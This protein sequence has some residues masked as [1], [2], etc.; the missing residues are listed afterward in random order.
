MYIIYI[1]IR[2]DAWMS[3]GNAFIY[4][5]RNV[6]IM[7]LYIYLFIHA[8]HI[9]IHTTRMHYECEVILEK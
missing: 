8:L 4:V 2:Y 5:M 9:Y 3:R 1:Q 7:L 6:D